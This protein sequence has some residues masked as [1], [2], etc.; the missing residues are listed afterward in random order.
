MTV[1]IKALHEPRNSQPSRTS[2]QLSSPRPAL[3]KSAGAREEEG[4][5]PHVW[6]PEQRGLF[7]TFAAE[8]ALQLVYYAALPQVLAWADPALGAAAAGST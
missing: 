8:S 4:G 5:N 7:W 1:I 6:S 2:S 3:N